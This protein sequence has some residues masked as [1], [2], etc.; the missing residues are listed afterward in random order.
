MN[1]SLIGSVANS[2]YWHFPGDFAVTAV[3]ASD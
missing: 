1:G 3:A 2:K